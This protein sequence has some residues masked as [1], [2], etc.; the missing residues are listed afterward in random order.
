[1][2]KQNIRRIAKECK[3]G[4]YQV[5]RMED[6]ENILK[7]YKDKLL[8]D[9]EELTFTQVERLEK[10]I[11]TYEEYIFR[12]YPTLKEKLEKEEQERIKN[13]E[14]ILKGVEV[15][16]ITFDDNGHIL[17]DAVV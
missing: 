16:H 14:E 10:N 17:T 15:H 11:K 3:N 6:A 2:W 7:Y 12:A 8:E 1:M 5:P 9:E 13:M 4:T